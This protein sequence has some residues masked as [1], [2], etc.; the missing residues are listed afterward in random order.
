MYNY[1]YTL[2]GS[3]YEIG[4]VPAEVARYYIKNRDVLLFFLQ[5]T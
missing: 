4:Y 5:Q 3:I 2:W 1:I